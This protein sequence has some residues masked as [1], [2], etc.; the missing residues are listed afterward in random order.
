MKR[1]LRIALAMAVGIIGGTAS[2]AWLAR[3]APFRDIMGRMCNRGRLL[4]IASGT[5]VYEA[6]VPSSSAQAIRAAIRLRERPALS[7]SGEYF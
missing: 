5:G 4:A 7:P 2:S 3:S 6:D 1:A